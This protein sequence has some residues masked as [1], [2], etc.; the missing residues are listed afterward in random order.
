MNNTIKK[1]LIMKKRKKKISSITAYDAS[2]ARVAEQANIDFILVGDSLGMVIQGCD[3]THKVTVE[4]M[5]YHIKC[6]EKG[7]KNTPIMA[8]LPRVALK[9]KKTAYSSVK[10]ILKAGASIIKIEYQDKS[11]G[12]IEYLLKKKITVCCHLGL[13][14]QFIKSSRDIK[15][16]GKTNK[17][18]KEIIAQADLLNGAGVSMI[19]LECVDSKVAKFISKKVDIPVIGIGSGQHTDGQISVLYDLI[20]ISKKIPSFAKNYLKNKNS[21]YSALK[22]YNQDVKK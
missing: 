5:V 10:K 3:N 19:L 22:N 12:L 21:V 15:V 2:F 16:H 9:N 6:V 4:E 17:S 14:P 11:F 18:A 7:V 8:D 13:K 1:L 20:G